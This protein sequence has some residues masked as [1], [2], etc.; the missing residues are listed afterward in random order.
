M[1]VYVMGDRAIRREPATADDRPVH[2]LNAAV[3]AVAAPH[4]AGGRPMP[5]QMLSH[6]LDDGPHL[7]ALRGARRAKDD[8]DRC[9]TP[10]VID[11]HVREAALVVMRVPEGKLLA[12]MRCTERIVDVELSTSPGVTDAQN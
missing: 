3:M 12:A 6:V 10:Y 9:A 5:S 2:R 8:G 7:R 11:V 4:D 1:R